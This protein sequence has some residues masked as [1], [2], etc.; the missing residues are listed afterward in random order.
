MNTPR[1]ILLNRHQSA[2][3][4]LD[5]LRQQVL[6]S[7]LGQPD[8]ERASLAGAGWLTELWRQ[9]VLPCRATW[10]GLATA[11]MVILLLRLAAAEPARPSGKP[12][13]GWTGEDQAQLQEQR[14]LR[15]ELLGIVTVRP[16]RPVVTPGPH[17]ELA[18]VRTTALRRE[19]T[20]AV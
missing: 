14:R 6:Q 2:E 5:S 15:E 13:A 8:A 3:P 7:E 1:D 20:A 11:W 16:E 10:A 4:E 19:E 18:P 17:S 12:M 9:L